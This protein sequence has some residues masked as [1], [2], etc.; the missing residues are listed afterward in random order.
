MIIPTV[1]QERQNYKV[2]L[3]KNNQIIR[4]L[5]IYKIKLNKDFTKNDDL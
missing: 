4:G 5:E 3:E 2:F 1:A